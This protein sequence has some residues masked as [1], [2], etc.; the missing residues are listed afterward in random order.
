MPK[1]TIDNKKVE[2]DN[3]ATILDAADK[4]GIEIPTMCFLR[5]YKASTSCMLCVVK[6]NGSDRLLPACGTIAQDGMT[7]E[8]DSDQIHQA[9]KAAL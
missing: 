3:G 7:V 9:R 6:V 4:L 8:T 2:V 5:G 1:L